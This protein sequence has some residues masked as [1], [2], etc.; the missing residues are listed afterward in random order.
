MLRARLLSL[1]GRA[2]SFLVPFPCGR[3]AGD[4]HLRRQRQRFNGE[5]GDRT[6]HHHH[7]HNNRSTRSDRKHHARIHDHDRA[8]DQHHA[9]DHDHNSK[10]QQHHKQRGSE[11]DFHLLGSARAR[12]GWLAWPGLLYGT[13]GLAWTRFEQ[14]ISETITHTNPVTVAVSS[15]SGSTWEFGW[16]AGAGGE[17]KITDNWLFR[18]EYPTMTSATGLARLELAPPPASPAQLPSLQRA[19]RRPLDR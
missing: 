11:R 3:R 8:P 18:V 16:A 19:S 13:G 14:S 6:K 7:H 9:L 15:A 2:L 5:H 4:R 1:G 17:L 12:I 10:R